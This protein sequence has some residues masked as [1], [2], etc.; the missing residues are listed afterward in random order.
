VTSKEHADYI[1]LL[2]A[3]FHFRELSHLMRRSSKS[4]QTISIQTPV[5]ESSV[6]TEFEKVPSLKVSPRKIVL[7][8][9]K[10]GHSPAKIASPD[11]SLVDTETIRVLNGN[12][13]MI[14]DKVEKSASEMNSKLSN[15]EI[16]VASKTQGLHSQLEQVKGEIGNDSFIF[17]SF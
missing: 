7:S 1:P 9:R 12:I 15:V 17:N 2:E 8:P 6:Q 14:L 13:Q 16:V 4:T 3:S 10:L 11:V 5:R